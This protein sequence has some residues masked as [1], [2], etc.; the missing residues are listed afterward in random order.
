[1]IVKINIIVARNIKFPTAPAIEAREPKTVCVNSA[2]FEAKSS[3]E[4]C[5]VFKKFG[6]TDITNLNKQQAYIPESCTFFQN[7]IGTAPAIVKESEKFILVAFPGVPSELIH[8]F[9]K[10]E[11]FLSGKPISEQELGL[12]LLEEVASY[13]ETSMSRRKFILN[14]FGEKYDEI[15]GLGNKMDDNSKDPKE[16]IEVK[17]DVKEFTEMLVWTP[18][19][20]KSN[21]ESLTNFLKPNHNLKFFIINI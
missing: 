12:S 14:Y 20:T 18:T 7:D 1:M 16:T 6:R 3:S 10:L 5:P 9:E 21:I 4:D 2:N 17:N 11:K 13:C 8:L 15:N 19:E